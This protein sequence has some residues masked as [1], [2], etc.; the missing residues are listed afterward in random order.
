MALRLLGESGRGDGSRIHLR[1]TLQPDRPGPAMH[2]YRES[3]E[4]TEDF[5]RSSAILAVTVICA[6]SN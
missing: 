6:G 2:A 5:E 1:L 3:F 4:P